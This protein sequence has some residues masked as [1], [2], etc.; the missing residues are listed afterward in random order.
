[1][2]RILDFL[3]QTQAGGIYHD[4]ARARDK[5][6]L[7]SH[8]YVLALLSGEQVLGLNMGRFGIILHIN[9]LDALVIIYK[10]DSVVDLII[11]KRRDG[12]YYLLELV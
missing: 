8:H 5:Q 6:K 7:L 3:K 4:Q 1:M 9:K 10:V 2:E 11:V 12:E